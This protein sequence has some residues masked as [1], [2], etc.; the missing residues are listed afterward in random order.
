MKKLLIVVDMING[1]L[2]EGN[3]HDKNINNIVPA[4]ITQIES[5]INDGHDIVAFCDNHQ[6]DSKEFTSYPVHCLKETNESE[7]I[8]EL[9][10]YS[11]SM[12]IIP[13]NSTNGFFAPKFKEY[14]EN[15]ADYDEIVL[16]GCCSDICVLQLALSLKAYCNENNYDCKIV[17]DSK[18]CDTFAIEGHC[19][20]EYNRL[21]F[22]LMSNSGI[23]II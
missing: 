14:L 15:L 4:C 22:N 11:E 9:K 6:R 2:N 23:E 21:A 20:E 17:V 1:F 18:A 7:L 16:I 13:K 3:L 12:V 8:D 10:G 19:R 5:F